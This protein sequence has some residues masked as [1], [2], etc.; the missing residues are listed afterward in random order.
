M[1]KLILFLILCILAVSCIEHTPIS[2]HTL[3]AEYIE[4]TRRLGS[5]YEHAESMSLEIFPDG[6]GFSKYTKRIKCVKPYD[7]GLSNAMQIVTEELVKYCDADIGYTQSDEI[8][9]ILSRRSDKAEMFLGGRFQKLCSVL[10]SLATYHFNRQAKYFVTKGDAMALFDCRAFEVPD[11]ATAI[12]CLD[13]RALDCRRNSVSCMAQCHFS[14]KKLQG[15]KTREQRE[16]LEDIGESYWDMPEGYRN[17][18]YIK[19]VK[20]LRK[21]TAEELEVLPKK[22]QARTNPDLEIERTVLKV[23]TDS[24]LDAADAELFTFGE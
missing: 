6:K 24:I 12:K 4:N 22:H 1:K 20:E 17:G 21:F 9:L 18:I 13:W 7:L 3:R 23:I 11:K 10:A 8:T 15:K 14:H 5:T 19:R 2:V 16:M